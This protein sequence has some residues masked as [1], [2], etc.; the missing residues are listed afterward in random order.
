MH[1]PMTRPRNPK[2][3][4]VRRDRK[5]GR[6]ARAWSLLVTMLLIG[7]LVACGGDDDAGG[8]GGSGGGGDCSGSLEDAAADEGKV[9]I[10]SSQGLDQLNDLAERFEKANPDISVEVVRGTDTDL[11]PRV[12][13]EHQT[14]RGAADIFVTA[15]QGWVEGYADQGWFVE[16]TGPN[17]EDSAYDAE[18]YLH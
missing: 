7:G 8:G 12:E 3:T 2:E 5:I 1:G 11:S 15:S 10:Y 9:T 4:H 13:A 18:E 17:F 6:P 16:P 14:G